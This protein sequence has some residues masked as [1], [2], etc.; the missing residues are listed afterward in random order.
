MRFALTLS[1]VFASTGFAQ[2]KA[3]APV[4]PIQVVKLD[5]KDAVQFDKEIVPILVKKCQVCHSG[6]NK[7]SQFDISTPELLMKGGKRG[8]P[9]VPGKSAESLLVLLAGKT[10][11]PF[12]PPKDEEP[13]TPQELALLKLWIDQGAKMATIV[14]EKPKIVVASLPASVHPVRAIAFRPDKPQVAAGRGNQV[15]IYDAA[16]GALV[17]TLSAEG[18]LAAVD[19]LAFSPNGKLVAAGTFQEVILWDADSGKLVRR[20]T[21]FADRVMALAFSPNSEWLATGGGAPTEDG[22]IKVFAV[23]TGNLVVDIKNGHSDTVFGVAFSPDGAKLATCA[24]DKFIKVFHL[25][26]GKFLKS[27][28]GHTHHVL[29]VA[30]K[31]DGKLLASAGADNVIKVWDYEKGEQVRTFGQS[32]KQITRL[33]FKGKT[34]D[35]V[36][37]NGDQTVNFWN[38][39]SGGAG[40]TIGGSNDFLYAVGI[41]AD[42]KFV[43]AGGEEGIVRLYNGANGQLIKALDPAASPAK[44]P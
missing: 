25:P 18:L 1:L 34:S 39:D 31:F 36:T 30:W 15:T 41:S 33:V 20:L 32:S 42:G 7:E 44:K 35:I 23:A 10:K 27:F 22:E 12:M 13:L 17:R 26:D 11:K 4:P 29:D 40:M 37:C 24:A 43:A 6:A 3:P 38:V 28:E 5:H 2:N 8:R 9:I 21:G 14:R 16:T 19:S